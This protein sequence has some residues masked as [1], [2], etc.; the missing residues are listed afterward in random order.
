[1]LLGKSIFCVLAVCCALGVLFG[2]TGVFAQTTLEHDTDRLGNDYR[3][4]ELTKPDPKL[5]KHACATDPKCRAF[6]YVKPGVQGERALCHLKNPAPEASSDT[7]CIS[8]LKMAR[9][10]ATNRPHKV[11]VTLEANTDRFGNDYNHI[12]LDTPDPERCRSLCE[13]DKKCQAF[14]YVKPGVQGESAI[15][16]LKNPAPEAAPDNCCV[17]GRRISR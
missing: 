16:Y 17:S 11:I 5:C 9:G 14:S 3:S 8:G 6:T 2:V 15:C 13:Q 7:C 12:K 10:G 4:F 1:M